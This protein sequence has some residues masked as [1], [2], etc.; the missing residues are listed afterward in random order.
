MFTFFLSLFTMFMTPVGLA[1]DAM[2]AAV[3]AQAAVAPRLD[4]LDGIWRTDAL[5]MKCGMTKIGI[6]CREEGQGETMKGAAADLAFTDGDGAASTLSVTLPS[7]PPS[8][9]TEVSRE[10]QSVTFE[11]KTKVGMARLRFTRTGDEL[12]IERGNPQAWATTM[13]Y[14]KG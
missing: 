13:T 4:W 1:A 2:P 11:M 7:V 6:A 10:G 12:K 5:E 9:F 14:R 8:N 3:P